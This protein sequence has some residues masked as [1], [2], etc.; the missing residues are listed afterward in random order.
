[1]NHMK[2]PLIAV[3]FA[4][5]SYPAVASEPWVQ[6]IPHELTG[7]VQIGDQSLLGC[8]SMPRRSRRFPI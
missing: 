4:L 8:L 1:M 3:L 7:K 6:A 5:T 2:L